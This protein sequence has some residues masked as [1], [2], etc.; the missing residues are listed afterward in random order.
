M[1]FDEL[2]NFDSTSPKLSQAH[3]DFQ[4]G[5]ISL[6]YQGQFQRRT[7]CESRQI[8]QNPRPVVQFQKFQTTKLLLWG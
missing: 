4:G 2:R 1:K 6:Y 7:E 3:L 8:A 5:G